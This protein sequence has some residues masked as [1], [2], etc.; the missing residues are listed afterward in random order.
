LRKVLGNPS[1][2]DLI[3][4]EK[5]KANYNSFLSNGPF[6]LTLFAVFLI[7]GVSNMTRSALEAK[8][9]ISFGNVLGYN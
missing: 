7:F 2:G 9:F 1:N 8:A 4:V 3:L 5:S 6:I